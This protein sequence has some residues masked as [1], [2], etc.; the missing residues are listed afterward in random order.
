MRK[1]DLQ[2]LLSKITPYITKITQDR[3]KLILAILVILVILF[4]DFSFGLRTQTRA[5]RAVDSKIVGLKKGL[6]NLR[7]DLDMMKRQEAGLAIGGE[8]KLISADQI[9][10][11]IEE[12]SRLAN[13]QGVRIFQVKPVRQVSIAK[14]TEKSASKDEHP[15]ILINLELS[16]GYHGLGRFL[17]ELENHSIYQEI[18]ELDINPNEKNPFEHD[19]NLVLKTYV[20][21]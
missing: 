14:S 10:W 4:M 20:S 18:K 9:P 17:A 8:K 19:V 12:L 5:L 21:E 13:Q 6:E 2:K 7:S 11:I 15:P 16:S 3:N 1:I